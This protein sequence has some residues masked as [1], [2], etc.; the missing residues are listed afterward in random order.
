MKNPRPDKKANSDDMAMFAGAI[1]GNAQYFQAAIFWGDARRHLLNY[2]WRFELHLFKKFLYPDA[3]ALIGAGNY[4]Q[5]FF[6]R[7][8]ECRCMDACKGVIFDSEPFQKIC[9]L[10]PLIDF[11]RLG[12]QEHG[13]STNH[14]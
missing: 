1:T 10:S 6:Q 8:I 7:E 2:L 12:G 5:P 4:F 13:G 11:L 14:F 9:D 3:I